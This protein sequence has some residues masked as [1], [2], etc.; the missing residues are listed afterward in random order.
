MPGFGW[1]FG[2]RVM[3]IIGTISTPERGATEASPPHGLRPDAKVIHISADPLA[4]RFPFRE[5][6]TDLLITG[7][8]RAALRLLRECLAG[9][10]RAKNG[11]ADGRRKT[12]AAAREEMAA[13]KKKLIETVKDQTPV[14]PAWRLQMRSWRYLH[15]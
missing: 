13:K 4:S 11:A 2:S 1:N 6:E 9:S 5:I 15:I 3:L 8:P 7:A 14:H 12:I 10:A